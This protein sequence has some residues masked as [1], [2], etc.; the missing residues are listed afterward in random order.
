MPPEG[1]VISQS[2]ALAVRVSACNPGLANLMLEQ[3]GGPQGELAAAWLSAVHVNR[4]LM[5]L[6]G[7]GLVSLHRGTLT[8]GMIELPAAYGELRTN[9]MYGFAERR[10]QVDPW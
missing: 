9:S 3:F 1:R 8:Q 10:G 5:R 6:R 7:A 2:R 4:I